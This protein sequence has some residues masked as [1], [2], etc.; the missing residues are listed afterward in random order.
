MVLRAE[1]QV[2]HISTHAPAGGATR[3]ASVSRRRKADFYSRPC[4]RGDTDIGNAFKHPIQFL[5]TPLRE[6]RPVSRSV[7][8]VF[9]YFYSRPCGRGDADGVKINGNVTVFLLTPL[10]EGRPEL[11]AQLQRLV[12]FLLT[13]L[14]E[15]RPG[16]RRA[17]PA[18]IAISTHA[19][20]GGATPTAQETA[21]RASYFYSRPCG[22]GD[23]SA[24]SPR[25]WR[26]RFLLTPLREG[27]LRRWRLP[28]RKGPI[29]T[30]APA[31]GATAALDG[32]ACHLADFYSRPCGRGDQGGD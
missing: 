17:D 4:G 8:V 7:A 13:P 28:G 31:G 14:R 15:G 5:L 2:R 6:G 32:V 24:P 20:A 9:A 19:P 3:S 30:H 22:R 23:S 29:S 16:S 11:L 18:R 10:R 25:R 27:R 21:R 1:R 12:R 26:C